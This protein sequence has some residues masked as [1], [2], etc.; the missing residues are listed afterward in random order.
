ML[1]GIALFGVR[2]VSLWTGRCIA[3]MAIVAASAYR[4]FADITCPGCALRTSFRIDIVLN[5]VSW[6]AS[7][8]PSGVPRVHTKGLLA[9]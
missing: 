3:T 5:P 6:I 4:G 2:K 9:P 7:P 1:S 8:V